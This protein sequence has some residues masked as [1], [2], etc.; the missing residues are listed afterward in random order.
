[1]RKKL[2]I[3]DIDILSKGVSG[4]PAF[5][6][7][8]IE[9]L[10]YDNLLLVDR[11]YIKNYL[12]KKYSIFK[13]FLF[14]S[15]FPEVYKQVI[16]QCFVVQFF[17]IHKKNY[18]FYSPYHNLFL[19]FSKNL[20][21]TIHDMVFFDHPE[22]YSFKANLFYRFLLKHNL[23]KA[24]KIIT[25]SENTKNSLV[26][27]F[28][29]DKSIYIIR[30]SYSKF[31]LNK[32]IYVRLMNEDYLFYCG[33][34]NKRKN[35]NFMFDLYQNYLKVSQNPFKLVC[36]LNKE[37]YLDFVSNESALEN[38][39]FTGKVKEDDLY[40]LY[41]YSSAVLYFSLYEGF[42]RPVMDSTYYNKPIYCND[43][44]VYKE[45]GNKNIITIK[46]KNDIIE[47]IV[48]LEKVPYNNR[49]NYNKK[50]DPKKNAEKLKRALIYD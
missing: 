47:S 9:H 12:I 35:L 22:F 36:T 43:L 18:V 37:N 3:V 7:N 13:I 40:N 44:E 10:D 26:E 5:L 21:C 38:V 32:K 30:N 28:K 8:L 1:M 50:F 49:I 4:I 48:N 15:N 16:Y 24:K 45:I 17:L 46:N 41:Y 11:N 19:P 23:K 29:V 6:R 33:G 27:T 25:I 2:L 31:Q 42:G 39:I 34:T 14:I 20:V